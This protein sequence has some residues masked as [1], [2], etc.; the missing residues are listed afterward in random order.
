MKTPTEIIQTA[1]G[2]GRKALLEHEAKELARAVGIAVP[3]YELVD[4][5]DK[6]A[7]F[8]A[9][10]R[11][12]FP[13]ALKAVSPEVLHKTD[14]G[15]VALDIANYEEL[16]EAADSMKK[17]VSERVPGAMIRYFLLEEMMAP[18]L[19][20]LIGGLR[21]VQFGPAVAFG[22]GGIWVEALKD[23]AFGI[24][25]MTNQETLDMMAGTKA[26]KFLKGFRGSAPLDEK[27]AI[28]IIKAVSQLMTGFT[29]IQEIDL[30]PVRVYPAGAVALDVRVI[31]R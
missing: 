25:P 4:A 12:G 17:R 14:A 10:K 30:N 18:G 11:L 2:E 9:A 24:L 8:M 23:T 28:S 27:S 16:V 6:Q 13:L 29:E 26:G 21:D 7:L 3:R 1:I 15:A 31:L 19:E 22:L 20:L 5:H